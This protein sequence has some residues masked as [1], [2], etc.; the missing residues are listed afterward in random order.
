LVEVAYPMERNCAVEEAVVMR[1]PVY[2][3]SALHVFVVVVAGK[4]PR[5]AVRA[6]SV[7]KYWLVLPS[8]S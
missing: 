8:S 2:E 5:T 7:V 6:R 1:P 4:R 3:F